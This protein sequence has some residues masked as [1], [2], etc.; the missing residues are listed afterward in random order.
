MMDNHPSDRKVTLHHYWDIFTKHLYIMFIHPGNDIC[1][2][3][4]ISSAVLQNYV[5]DKE[6]SKTPANSESHKAVA[7]KAQ[8]FIKFITKG[9]SDLRAI[10]LNLQQT[11]ATPQLSSNNTQ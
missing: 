2:K 11:L 9:D 1:I 8:N 7:W 5:C 4:D 3:C 10:C 6:C